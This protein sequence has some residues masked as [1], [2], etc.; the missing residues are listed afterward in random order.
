MCY[1]TVNS[2]IQCP[3]I[4]QIDGLTHLKDDLDNEKWKYIYRRVLIA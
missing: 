1:Y 2:L 4:D 3:F